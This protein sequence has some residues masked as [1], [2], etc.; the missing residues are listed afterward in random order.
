MRNNYI[1]KIVEEPKN[2]L[3]LAFIEEKTKPT[4]F[5][6]ENCNGQSLE[7]PTLLDDVLLV[8]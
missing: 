1:P 2:L 4:H 5:H 3:G 7:D 6:C 8:N